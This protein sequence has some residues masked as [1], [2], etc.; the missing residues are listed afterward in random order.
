MIGREYNISADGSVMDPSIK[1]EYS[2]E[3]SID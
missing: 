2:S 3:R 1:G